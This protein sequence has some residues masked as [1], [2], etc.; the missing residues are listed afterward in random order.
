MRLRC[1]HCAGTVDGSLN[2]SGR[3][4]PKDWDPTVCPHCGHVAA[5]EHTTPGGLR[6][7]DETDWAIWNRD[8]TLMRAI[9][10]HIAAVTN[11]NDRSS[12]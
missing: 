6:P 3:P 11:L 8:P 4:D 1:P 10:A 9:A 5:Y 2:P 7:P 12:E